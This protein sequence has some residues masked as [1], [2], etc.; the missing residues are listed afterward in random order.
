MAKRF[1][2]IG[3]GTPDSGG[4]A[5]MPAILA[6]LQALEEALSAF[7]SVYRNEPERRHFGEYLTGL[8]IAQRKTVLGMISEFVEART[9]RA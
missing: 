5:S 6:F 8:M 1:D 2:F 9:S 4:E 3:I 7:S